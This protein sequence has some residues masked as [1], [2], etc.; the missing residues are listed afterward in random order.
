MDDDD[1]PT[2]TGVRVKNSQRAR[3]DGAATDLAVL[4]WSVGLAGS[5]AATGR[6]DDHGDLF[7]CCHCY[8]LLDRIVSRGLTVVVSE[9]QCFP[10]YALMW[11]YRVARCGH[12]V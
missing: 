1:D 7:V 11:G 10:K 4:L 8:A 5:L 9:G 12:P 2:D 3:D 6:H